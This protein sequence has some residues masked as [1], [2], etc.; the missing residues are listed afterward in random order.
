M[1]TPPLLARANALHQR[2]IHT[3][4]ARDRQANTAI[5]G[6]RTRG[7]FF[8]LATSR[9]ARPIAAQRPSLNPRPAAA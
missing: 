6:T 2:D 8:H 4:I 1:I 5:A 9:T 3:D 7:G